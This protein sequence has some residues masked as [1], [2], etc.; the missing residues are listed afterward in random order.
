MRKTILILISLVLA[1]QKGAIAET[2]YS[3]ELFPKMFSDKNFSAEIWAYSITASDTLNMVF[4]GGK[5]FLGGEKA[6]IMAVNLDNN[7]T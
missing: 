5:S 1:F 4:Q 6:W 7:R 2:C 3:K